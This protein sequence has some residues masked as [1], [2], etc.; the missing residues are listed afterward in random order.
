MA[1]KYKIVGPRNPLAL[2]TEFVKVGD[3]DPV[4]VGG[5]IEL[6]AAERDALAVT[7]ILEGKDGKRY[8]DGSANDDVPEAPVLGDGQ[9]GANTIEQVEEAEGGDK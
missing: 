1:E 9:G 6:S 8:G 4:R 3:G 5:E 2:P 7:V